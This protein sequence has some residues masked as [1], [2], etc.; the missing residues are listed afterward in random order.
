MENRSRTTSIALAAA[1]AV[2]GAQAVTSGTATAAEKIPG[3]EHFLAQGCNQCHSVKSA[4]I[5]VKSDGEKPELEEGGPVPPD[6]SGVGKKHDSK[7]LHLFVTKQVEL[8]DKKHMKKF[9][10]TP[11]ELDELVNWLLTLKADK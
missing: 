2:V 3:M 5:E 9:K 7:F 4:G 11:E 10:G 8:H 1:A 6:L